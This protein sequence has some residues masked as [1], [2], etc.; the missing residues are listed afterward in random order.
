MIAEKKALMKG[1]EEVRVPEWFYKEATFCGLHKAGFLWWSN[2]WAM[3]FHLILATV[4]VVVSTLN[5]KTMATPRLSLY[6]TNIS[7]TPNVTDA[8][9]PEYTRIEGLYLAHMVLWFFL[10]SALAHGTVVIFNYRQA[11]AEDGDFEGKRKVVTRWTG[12]YFIN[13]AECRNPHRWIE[14]SFS[15]SLMGMV[16]A[17]AGGINH[18]YMVLYTFGLLWATMYFGHVAE[19]V[20]RPVPPEKYDDPPQTWQMTND[21]PYLLSVP[22]L[23]AKFNRLLPNLLGYVP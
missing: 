14:Y 13:I 16:F 2:F 9:V 11:Y 17:V 3:V 7:W 18:L 23:G 20:N 8:L 19:I 6:L 5:G 4:S 21:K 22:E 1:K 12:W 10:L 15:A